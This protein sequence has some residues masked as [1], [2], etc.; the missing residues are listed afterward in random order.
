MTSDKYVLTIDGKDFWFK[1][2][3]EVDKYSLHLEKLSYD[4]GLYRPAEMLVT[5][6]I[7]GQGI[8][9]DQLVKAFYMKDV[10]LKIN[11]EM[12]AENYFVFKVRPIFQRTS[13]GTGSKVELTIYSQDKLMT[14]D[15]YSKAWTGQKL[16]TNIFKDEMKGFNFNG[17]PISTSCD[18]QVVDYGSSE[19]IQPYLVQYNESFYDFLRRTANRCGEFLYH[20][21][22]SLHLGMK[23]NDIAKEKDPD[24]AERAYKRY[25]EN[26][27]RE[28]TET[29]DF[30]YNY[31][32]EN[33]NMPEKDDKPYSNPLTYDDYL[34]DVKR[35]YTDM[36]EQFDYISKNI[37]NSLCLALGGTSLLSI[38]QNEIVTNGFKLLHAT[39][40]ATNLN[41]KHA[42]GNITPWAGIGEQNGDK[43]RQFG[44]YKDQTP[45]NNFCGQKVNMNAEF[46]ALVREAEKKVS[47]NAVYLEFDED[48]Q[49]L[50]IGDKIKVDGEYY[51][52]IGV[53]GSCIYSYTDE[54]S[55]ATFDERQQ[56]IA[57]KLYGEA[58]IPPAL[59]DIIVRES[60]P[61]LAFVVD[62]FDPEKFGRVRVKFAWQPKEEEDKEK[63]NASPWIRVS[64]P[65]ATDGAGVKFKPEIGDEVMVSFEEGNVERP[66]VS[67][68]LLSPRTNKTWSW[69][70]DR[71]I[72][73]KN[74]HTITFNDGID[75]ASSLYALLPF[76]K[77]VRSFLPNAVIPPELS[78]SAIFRGLTGGMT[79]SDRFGLYKINLS[80]DSR[81]VFIQSPVGDVTLNAF[82]G[83]NI[84]APNGDISIQGKNIKLEASDTISIES[85]KAVKQR[86]LPGN[87]SYG[88]SGTF[89]DSTAGRVIADVG[90]TF[91]RD[92]R[93]R[94]ID[95]VVDVKLIRTLMDTVLRPID[96]TLKIKSPTFVR[97]EAGKGSAEYPRSARRKNGDLEHV[98]YDLYPSI[99]KV[100]SIAR[101]R[102][103]F[104]QSAYENMCKDIAAFNVFSQAACVN[105]N[106]K[107]I[108]VAD[109]K[110]ASFKNNKSDLVFNWDPLKTVDELTND[111]QD[112]YNNLRNE[113][114]KE[115]DDL[116]VWIEGNAIY[117]RDM[118]EW[119]QKLRKLQ[120]TYANNLNK[121]N[122]TLHDREKV[123]NAARKLSDSIYSLYY[124]TKVYFNSKDVD[125]ENLIFANSIKGALDSLSYNKEIPIKN[126]TR[127]ETINDWAAQKKHYMRLAVC[128]FFSQSELSSKVSSK[129]NNKYMTLSEP[130]GVA[131]N[132]ADDITW[133]TCVGSMVSKP[134]TAEKIRLMIKE[135]ADETYK[136]PYE[137]P[138][139]NQHRW[140]VGVDGKI[141]MSDNPGKTMTFDNKGVVHATGNMAF[142][143]KSCDDLKNI[144]CSIGTNVE[145]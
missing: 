14:L 110:N 140:K 40:A 87:E 97:I 49:K 30:A 142:T 59:P 113:K 64:L 71:S 99:T 105:A 12:V 70:P 61:Q 101:S 43:V 130:T 29:S 28:G 27:L 111:Y 108:S 89:W 121:R 19:F 95:K 5:M 131:D 3:Q 88:E 74:G 35:N 80:S 45:K 129:V 13:N 55:K 138:I 119:N 132:L 37:V 11:D 24:Y 77:L 115:D 44:T 63:E 98:P 46:Y 124:F 54:S 38:I 66:Y 125:C 7:G 91:L 128:S 122:K 93:S 68:F 21:N 107:A 8:K 16:G 42:D 84:S 137:D 106:E 4:K 15:K 126:D 58:A 109:I 94:T 102:V 133:Q 134:T 10:K 22:G 57:V 117:H 1:K 73:S 53:N 34:D 112:K 141:L 103:D 72:T 67:G 32:S 118:E 86:F 83:I 81:S 65:F 145:K 75:G 120:E 56:V 79:L 82:T 17:Q 127:K 100:A 18:L 26:I 96:G 76:W 31:L 92:I 2:D 36:W 104:V 25:Y 135:W 52:V 85:G 136:D 23:M 139:V 48:T 50:S 47:E 123:E 51:V 62:N 33:R 20:E 116:Y 41:Q 9:N 78:D 144:L 114:P 60:Q 90:L 39:T 143:D 69:L 6:N